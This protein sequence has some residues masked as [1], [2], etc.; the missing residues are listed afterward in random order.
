MQAELKAVRTAAHSTE[1]VDGFRVLHSAN[2][3]DT[4]RLYAALSKGIA[5]RPPP[6]HTCPAVAYRGACSLHASTAGVHAARKGCGEY[7]QALLRQF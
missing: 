2:V 4:F 3:A 6:L 7:E 1:V 5:A